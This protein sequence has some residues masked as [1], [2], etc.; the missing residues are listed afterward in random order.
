MRWLI[1]IIDLNIEHNAQNC[2]YFFNDR[3]DLDW[4]KAL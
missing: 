2:D 4:N 1:N 3:N